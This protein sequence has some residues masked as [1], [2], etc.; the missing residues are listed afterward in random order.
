M[1]LVVI[2]LLLAFVAIGKFNQRLAHNVNGR[3]CVW[4]LQTPQNM[5]QSSSKPAQPFVKSVEDINQRARVHLREGAVTANYQANPENICALLNEALATE[6]VCTLRYR[7]HYFNAKGLIYHPVADMFLEHSEREQEH[8]D[9]IAERIKQ[10]NGTPNLDPGEAALHS[11]TQYTSGATLMEMIE[12][13]LVAERV[14]IEHYRDL[15]QH[16]GQTDPTTRVLIEHLL[17]EE[18]EHAEELNTLLEQMGRQAQPGELT[19]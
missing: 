1:L 14:V 10:L 9:E 6:I 5:V 8:V 4:K 11:I 18:E 17:K 13:D 16:V 12:E 7:A 15:I 3:L 19:S 2:P